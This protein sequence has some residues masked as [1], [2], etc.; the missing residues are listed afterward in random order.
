L[1]GE[2]VIAQKQVTNDTVFKA[3]AGKK[4][5][6]N[7]TNVAKITATLQELV[8]SLVWCNCAASSISLISRRDTARKTGKRSPSTSTARTRDRQDPH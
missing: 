6:K 3:A 7:M 8:M 5:L 1:V 2:A 4:L